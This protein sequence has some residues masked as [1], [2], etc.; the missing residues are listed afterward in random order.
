MQ[1]IQAKC[2][3]KLPSKGNITIRN[4]CLLVYSNNRRGGTRSVAKFVE[5]RRE[6]LP[7]SQRSL[8]PG[9]ALTLQTDGDVPLEIQNHDPTRDYQHRK[10]HTPPETEIENNSLPEAKSERKTNTR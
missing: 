4:D 9:G 7:D 1:N 3:E 5:E 8:T 6:Q 10:K 2:L